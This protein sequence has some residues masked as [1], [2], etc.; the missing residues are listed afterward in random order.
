MQS[1]GIRARWDIRDSGTEPTKSGVVG[2][3]GCALGIA[4]S[5]ERLEELDRQLVFA[6]RTD[7]PG[8]IATDYQTITG[9]HRMA[10]GKKK[11]DDY[12]VQSFRD[13]IHDAAFLVGLQGSLKLLETLASALANPHWPMFLGRKSCIPTRP[14]LDRISSDFDSLE[15]AIRQLE[16]A[17]PRP[18]ARGSTT[19]TLEAWVEVRPGE[20]G[21][22]AAAERQ[23]AV[24]VNQLRAYDFHRCR[25]VVVDVEGLSLQ[26]R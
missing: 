16:W 4:R 19:K 14:V 9:L 13:Y 5:D 18:S 22:D 3:L 25:R 6:V 21:W 11:P 17:A 15:S 12:T 23:N 24:R 1:W 20:P 2:I 26:E 8:T 10:S 7:R